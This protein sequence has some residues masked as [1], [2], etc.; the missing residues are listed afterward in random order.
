[1]A[2]WIVPPKALCLNRRLEQTMKRLKQGVLI[3]FEGVDGVGKSTQ[4]KALYAR[5]RA[6]RFEAVLSKEPTDGTWGQKLRRLI[7]QGRK[8]TTPQE[9]LDWFIEDRAEHVKRTIN[10]GLQEKRIVVLDRYY[11]ST[12]AYQSPLGFDPEEIKRRNLTFAPP[13]DLLFLIELPPRSGLRR[14][15]ENR[16]KEAD[17]FEKEDY[18]LR[19]DEIFRGMRGP[20]L[21]RLPGEETIQELSNRAWN[22]TMAH[23]K[24]RDLVEE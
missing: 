6:A 12:I 19:V 15:V 16:G 5:L 21:H 17:S 9:E 20:F 8:D 24:E 10:P 1:M 7:E 18:L 2:S 4:A 22:I 11:F 13:P 14:I 3:V 23:L